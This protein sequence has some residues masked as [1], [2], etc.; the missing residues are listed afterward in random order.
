MR[1]TV[2]TAVSLL[3]LLALSRLG[4]GRSENLEA[5]PESKPTGRS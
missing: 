2:R 3:A 5:T 4:S 1:T